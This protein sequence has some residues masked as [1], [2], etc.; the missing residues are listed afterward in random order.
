MLKA[1]R[2]LVLLVPQALLV[3]PARKAQS[4][5]PVP[6]ASLR[7]VLLVQPDLLVMQARKAR[8]GR[9]AHEAPLV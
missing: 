2:W 1:G 7:P 9:W 6:E 5:L 8:P 3:L 4:E